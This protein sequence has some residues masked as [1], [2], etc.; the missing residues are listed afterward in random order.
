MDQHSRTGRGGSMFIVGDPF[1]NIIVGQTEFAL[2]ILRLIKIKVFVISKYS[3][4]TQ[5]MMFKF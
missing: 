4:I 2:Q 3:I 5:I 1:A